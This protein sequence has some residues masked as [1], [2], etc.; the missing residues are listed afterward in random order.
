[1][2]VPAEASAP[3][4]GVVTADPSTPWWLWLS[5]PIATLAIGASLSGI[6]VD[7]V[8]ARETENFAAQGVGQDI[9]NLIAYPILLLLEDAEPSE[10]GAHRSAARRPGSAA[11]CP[12]G[13][14]AGPPTTTGHRT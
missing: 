11:S 7:S 5:V 9:A 10:V 1:M 6:F 3:D 14:Q 12:R 4:A 8:Y 2:R 13:S